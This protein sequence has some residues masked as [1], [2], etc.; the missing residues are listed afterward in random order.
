MADTISNVMS[1]LPD[2]AALS[3]LASKF[4]D[5][6][7]IITKFYPLLKDS[8]IP[9]IAQKT[10]EII[11]SIPLQKTR[12]FAQTL[13][14]PISVNLLMVLSV[15]LIFVSVGFYSYA[16]YNKWYGDD[17]NKDIT[18]GLETGSYVLDSLLFTIILSFIY[19]VSSYVKYGVEIIKTFA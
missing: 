5:V 19:F 13:E 16:I 7:E 12:E 1:N 9:D 2:T 10:S 6:P 3:D 14:V 18:R 4:K 8:V 17:T 11:S 15:I